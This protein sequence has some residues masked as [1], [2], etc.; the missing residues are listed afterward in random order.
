MIDH[1]LLAATATPDQIEALCDEAREHGLFSVCVNPLYVPLAA[2]RLQGSGVAVCTVVGFPLGANASATKAD[3]TRRAIAEGATEVDMVIPV[4]LMLAGEVNRVQ[5]DIAAVVGAA[6]GVLVKVIFETGHLSPEQIDEACRRSEA[7]GAQYVKT[8][9]GMG[10][11]GAS[12]GDIERM[13]A[14][15]GG[16]LG[17]KASGGIRNAEAARAMIEAGAT[18]IGASA[19]INIL[20]GWE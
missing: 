4:G 2:G 5:Q 20:E 12:V 10:P 6:D 11:R 17:I 19:S 13:S 8:S 1:T 9:T 18:R 3:E 7:A 16:R 14:A 15:V